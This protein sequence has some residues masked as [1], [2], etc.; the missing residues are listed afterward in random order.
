MTPRYRAPSSRLGILV[1]VISAIALA[2][3]PTVWG[4]ADG[5]AGEPR[6]VVLFIGD[7]MGL[8]QVT[9]GRL[10]AG[11]AGRPYA[12]DRFRTI[13]LASTESLDSPVTDSA[14]AATALAGGVKP[15][16]GGVGVDGDL[17]PR[18]SLLEV[19]RDAGFAT[20][21]V[22][23]TRI[24]HA[25]PAGF[26]AHVAHRDLEDAIAGQLVESGVDVLCGG[27]RR[28]FGTDRIAALTTAGYAIAKDPAQLRA[29]ASLLAVKSSAERFARENSPPDGTAYDPEK[30]RKA[31]ATCYGFAPTDA[32]L[33]LARSGRGNDAAQMLVGHV[34][35]RRFGVGFFEVDF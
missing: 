19:A 33:A 11:R 18:R 29:P 26:A 32:E 16:N 8:S 4:R 27:G 30:L 10:A 28:S 23:T 2:T 15:R 1:A 24:T 34:A 14:A 7:G 21:L 22:T 31:I 6:R 5:P 13:G 35:S 20:G 17:R 3:V 9:L 12:F 25:T